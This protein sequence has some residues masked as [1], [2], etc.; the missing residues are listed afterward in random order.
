MM[1]HY[2]LEKKIL[3]FQE[4]IL[5]AI[6]TSLLMWQL[7]QR[8]LSI[9]TLM[10]LILFDPFRG[11]PVGRHYRYFGRVF[12][13]KCISSNFP[14][15]SCFHHILMRLMMHSVIFFINDFLKISIIG[16]YFHYDAGETVYIDKREEKSQG[17]PLRDTT[18]D[19]CWICED[20]IE[21]D[22]LCSIHLKILDPG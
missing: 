18:S 10:P 20:F 16:K 14:S 17:S 11:N 19:F 3:T 21:H 1:T 15:F 12:F 5:Q 8:L 7:Q 4:L 22:I 9:I 6:S 13:P 2:F